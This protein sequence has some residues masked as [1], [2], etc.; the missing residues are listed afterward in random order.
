MQDTGKYRNTKDQYYTNPI[1]ARLCID[2]LKRH[3][4][5]HGTWIEPSAGGGVFLDIV[6]DAIGYDIDPKDERIIKQ[7]FLETYVPENAVIFGNPPFGRQA[8]IAKK[9]IKHSAEKASIIAFILPKSFMKPSMQK[10][11]PPYFHLIESLH[12]PEDAFVVNGA[13]YSVPCVFQV[14][15]RKQTVRQTVE[16]EQPV[17]FSFV[18]DSE[19]YDIVFR[20]VGFY[21]GRCSLPENQSPQSHYFVKLEDVRH[22]SQIVAE[23]QKNWFVANTAGPNSISKG[24]ACVFLNGVIRSCA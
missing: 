2:T 16:A 22:V 24:E 4:T 15:M 21:A 13:P 18:K 12:L 8:S 7:D 17:G 1:V 14:W 3:A 6:P 23:S 10:S 11:F 20:R 5:Q 9:F 19:K